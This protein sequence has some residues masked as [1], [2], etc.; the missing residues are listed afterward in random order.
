MSRESCCRGW[1]AIASLL[2]AVA[3]PGS[4]ELSAQGSS[5]ASMEGVVVADSATPVAGATVTLTAVAKGVVR[6]VV[7]DAAGGF[8]FENLD[9]GYYRIGARRIGLG[10]ASVDSI[11]LNLGDRL[12]TRLFLSAQAHDLGNTIVAG[13]GMRNPG[14]GGPAQAIPREA[15]RNLPLLNRD[16]VGLFGMSSQ[17]VGP[18][19]LWVSGQHARFNAI[20]IDG[21]IGNDL[22]GVNVTAASNAG[23]KSIA[24]EALDEIRI[25]IAPFDVRQGGFSGGLI[26]AV[27]RSGTNELRGSVFSSYARSELVGADTAG[28][29]VPAFDQLRYGV[30]VG[31]P[32]VRDRLHYFVA[33]ESQAEASQFEGPSISDPATGITE[34]TADRAARVFRER[35]GFDPGGTAAPDLHQPNSNLFVKLSWHP[36]GNHSIDLTQS[37]SSA[38]ADQLGRLLRS[39]NSTDGWQL[40]NS[41]S[42]AK[43]RSFN[44]RLRAVSVFG[45]LTN[46]VIAGLSGTDGRADSRNEVPLFL[47]QGDVPNNYL[48]AGS[49]KGAQGTRTNQHVIELTDNVSLSTG[50]HLLTFGTQNVFF[51]V[52]DN[53]LLGSWGVWTFNSVDAL[54]RNEPSRYEVS[55][56]Q[57]R[58]DVL[59]NVRSSLLSFYAQDQ[60]RVAD[61]L[62]LTAGLRLDDPFFSAPRTNGA[63]AS[64]ATLGNIDTGRFP[65]GNFELSPRVG[66]ALDLG[67]SRSSML[68]GGAGVFAGRPPLT[69]LTGVYSTT[70]LDQTTLVCNNADGVPAATRDIHTL[71]AHCV[72]NSPTAA[73]PLV[74]FFDSDFRFQRAIKV[75]VGLDHDFGKSVFGSLDFIYTTSRD[76]LYLNDVNLVPLGTDSEGRAM[77]GTITSAGVARPTRLDSAAYG[78]V[79]RF[80]NVDSD[81]AVSLSASLQRKW[82]SGSLLQLG[83]NWS[84]AMDVMSLTGFTSTVIFRNSPVDGSLAKRNRTRSSRD[85]PH[86]FVAV[87]LV[88]LGGGVTSSLLFRARSGTPYAFTVSG[89]DANADGTTRNDLFYVPRSLSDFTLANPEAYPALEDLIESRP[90]LRAQRGQMMKRNSCRNPAVLSLDGRLARHFRVKGNRVAEVS[91]N[92][93]NVPNLL[94]R[95]WGLVR[96]TSNREDV[97]L[98]PISGWDSANNRPR[99][100]IPVLD[101]TAILPAIDRVVPDASRWRIQLGARFDF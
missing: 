35:L 14:S 76:N 82:H 84:R 100:S 63:L 44:T 46:E 52:E 91:A 18:G 22:F 25:F 24:L 96:E 23:G 71:P 77:Y 78:P 15:L 43:S 64:N 98:I 72:K 60:W 83:Y 32:I 9:L 101:G 90:C 69:W 50:R 87:A 58:K 59:A 26:S 86:T 11:S 97:P 21:A 47:V 89:G 4:A 6:R 73:K 67:S 55:M 1:I 56:L 2:G 62:M 37:L 38:R 79:F 39:S 7:T 49:V 48:A 17:A 45:A 70:G 99:Y 42:V 3:I 8:R 20:Q 34:A 31:G 75:D 29:G 94:N 5:G 13:A 68:R 41:G 36:S 66:F 10:S 33:A 27:T 85:I 51:H 81:R 74:G 19:S 16:F 93:F 12:R 88:P 61:R 40:S 92:L 28:S 80:S 65:S 95:R 57:R 53:F 30:S 54:E